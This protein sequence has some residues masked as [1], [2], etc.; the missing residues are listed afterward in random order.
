[1]DRTLLVDPQ[2]SGGLLIALPR[3]AVAEYLSRVEG[4]TEIGA[5]EPRSSLDI[6]V[7]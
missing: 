2:T 6:I 7:S 5:V 3:A 4:A 1:V